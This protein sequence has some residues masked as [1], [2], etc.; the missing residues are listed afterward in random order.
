MASTR[1][2]PQPIMLNGRGNC[3]RLFL[4]L[5]NVVVLI[6]GD[7]VTFSFELQ[8]LKALLVILLLLQ[9]ALQPLWVLAC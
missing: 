9:S 3:N 8:I 5:L 1:Q 4:R 2:S 7:Y 6:M